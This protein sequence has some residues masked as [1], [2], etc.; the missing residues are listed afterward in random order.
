MHTKSQVIIKPIRDKRDFYENNPE[1]VD[2]ILIEGTKKAQ[3]K[4]NERMTEIREV[5]K[6]NYFKN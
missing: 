5:M 6:L 1:I 2:K 4:A 3:Q